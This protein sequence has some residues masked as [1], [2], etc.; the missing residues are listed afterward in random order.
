MVLNHAE[1]WEYFETLLRS[2]LSAREAWNKL[3]DFHE[4]LS[5]GSYW[6]ALRQLDIEAEQIEIQAWLEKMIISS[7][8][9]ETI[10]SLWIGIFERMENEKALYTIYLIG[11][12]DF[13]DDLEWATMPAYEPE[14]RYGSLNILIEIK[15]IINSADGRTYA[16]LNWILPLAYCAFTFDEIIRVKLEKEIFL[17]SQTKLNVAVGYDDGDYMLLSPIVKK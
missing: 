13:D 4:R 17:K 15:K 9:P 7:P 2:G 11:S 3:I 5:P 16:F 12:D 6:L 14:N 8:L 10:I 1:S